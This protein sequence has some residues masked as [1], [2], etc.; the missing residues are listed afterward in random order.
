MLVNEVLKNFIFFPIT[1][2]TVNFIMLILSKFQILCDLFENM[3]C[4]VS[5]VHSVQ[6]G[7]PLS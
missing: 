1:F 5:I 3:Y 2:K 4:P 6:C 7:A